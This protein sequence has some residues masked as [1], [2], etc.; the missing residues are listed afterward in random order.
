MRKMFRPLTARGAATEPLF[1]LMVSATTASNN[2]AIC[3]LNMFDFTTNSERSLK[4]ITVVGRQLR[5]SSQIFA[6]RDS[7]RFS[8]IAKE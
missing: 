5:I 3:F 1:S 2:I 7:V 6:C 4:T 8:A